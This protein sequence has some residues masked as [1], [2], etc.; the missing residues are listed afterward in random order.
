MP[1][2]ALST[3]TISFGLVS[4]PIK[5]YTT[6]ES[7]AGVSFNMLHEACGTRLKQ[8]YICPKGDVIVSREETAKGSEFSKNQYVTKMSGMAAASRTRNTAQIQNLSERHSTAGPG[9]VGSTST[10]GWVARSI[11]LVMMT[12]P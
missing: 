5:L 4:I 8:Q 7:S 12:R 11:V 9:I 6:S 10:A 2:R 1:A 3:A